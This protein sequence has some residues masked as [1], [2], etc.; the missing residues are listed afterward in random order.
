MKNLAH[1]KENIAV[2][3]MQLKRA[4]VHILHQYHAAVQSYYCDLCGI[5]ESTCPKSVDIST[6]NRSLMYM[7]GYRNY[8]A[9][10]VNV[11]RDSAA[12]QCRCVL[13]LSGLHRLMRPGDEHCG[14]D[15]AGKKCIGVTV[16]TVRYRGY[17]DYRGK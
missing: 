12:S 6:I 4:D 9:C 8:S 14:A 10:A 16:E 3:G 2:M 1:F 7:E 11:P 15:G 17:R 5:C 13:G